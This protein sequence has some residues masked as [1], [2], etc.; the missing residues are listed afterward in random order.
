MAG[1]GR[2]AISRDFEG[3]EKSARSESSEGKRIASDYV[4]NLLHCVESPISVHRRVFK[5]VRQ[6]KKCQGL[7][8]ERRETLDVSTSVN[9]PIDEDSDHEHW[10]LSEH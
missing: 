10:I 6:L 5:N 4:R 7:H 9:E 1:P 3:S 8:S 2:G